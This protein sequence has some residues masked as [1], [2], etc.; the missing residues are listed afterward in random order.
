KALGYNKEDIEVIQKLGLN[1]RN[2]FYHPDDV[3]KISDLDKAVKQLK[4]GEIIKIEYRI[5]N[6]RSKW[7]WFQHTAAIFQK[8]TD[9]HPLLTINVFENISDRKKIEEELNKH[10]NEIELLYGAAKELTG[11]L[12][13]YEIYDRMYRIIS[14]VADCKELIVTSYNPKTSMIHYEYLKA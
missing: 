3:S 5:K 4:E 7:L 9:K 14:E 11:T 1:W 8:G 6:A 13:P 2:S 10:V 12:D